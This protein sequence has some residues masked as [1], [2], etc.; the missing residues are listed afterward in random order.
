MVERDRTSE[1]PPAK[2]RRRPTVVC[3]NCK[4]RKSKCDRLKPVCGN[5]LRLGDEATCVYGLE[6]AGE[7]RKPGT[8]RLVAQCFEMVRSTQPTL[9]DLQPGGVLIQCKRSCTSY[10]APLTPSAAK[11]RDP[12]L[13]ALGS[14]CQLKCT[15]RAAMPA[16][17]NEGPEEA[18]LRGSLPNSMRYIESIEQNSSGQP[19]SPTSKHK[20]MC[21]QLFTKFGKYRRDHTSSTEDDLEALP[22][23]VPAEKVFF[24]YIWPHF[25][26]H[27]LSLCPIFDEVR[28]EKSLRL[29]YE[30]F[31]GDT[32]PKPDIEDYACFSIVLL[33]TCLVQLSLK[34]AQSYTQG[35]VN[36]GVSVIMK[37]D[38][39]KFISMVNNCISRKKGHR[40]CSLLRL[41]CLLLLRFYHWCAPDDGDGD[42]LQYSNMMMGTIVAACYSMGIDWQCVRDPEDFTNN[43]NLC[44]G[45]MP[46]EA[47]YDASD[48]KKIWATVLHWDRKLSLLTGQRCLVGN[49][50]KL[51]ALDHESPPCALLKFDSLMLKICN[52]VSDDPRRVDVSAVIR[53]IE[54]LRQSLKK[55]TGD[56]AVNPVLGFEWG[57]VIA[58]LELTITH[59]HMVQ[60]ERTE[61]PDEFYDC[62]Q[63]LF[64]KVL[65]ITKICE[66]YLYSQEG[67]DPSA[68]FY[69]N[70]II[71]IAFSSVSAIFPCLI[72]RSGRSIEPHTKRTLLIFYRNIL[73]ASFNT[74]GVEYYTC[75]RRMFPSKLA[76][77]TLSSAGDGDPWTR[78]LEFI[79]SSDYN[80]EYALL[81]RS[82]VF[83]QFFKSY[84]K[85]GNIDTV[86][87]LWSAC[88]T[89]NDLY[90]FDLDVK[91]FG[92]QMPF[93]HSNRY[94]DYDVFAAFFNNAK[95][96][97]LAKLPNSP[98][99]NGTSPGQGTFSD[100]DYG[101][102][103]GIEDYDSADFLDF[104]EPGGGGVLTGLEPQGNPLSY[105]IS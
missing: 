101:L 38:T 105:N 100:F 98:A 49:S 60:S 15:K 54:M 81:Q 79:V 44:L 47:E 94:N 55:D 65:Q 18:S 97:F 58:L 76:Y 36:S 69:T 23:R 57:I 75:F 41:Q 9:I 10:I 73:S 6:P 53:L 83:K 2:K 48:Y 50:L 20:N 46:S 52:M 82:N 37:I 56:N 4:R 87:S 77:K 70:K 61:S 8:S 7:S 3:T 99:H 85:A 13:Q 78:I 89:P 29:V 27:V 72:L 21:R 59:A 62:I 102:L 93:S 14:I 28:L 74:I 92:L 22:S 67:L 1:G 63:G 96:P 30:R 34:F 104:F 40:K 16:P 5:C 88:Y 25:V 66:Q 35:N 68:R 24:R 32:H 64:E 84:E 11:Q 90:S 19:A 12:Y 91:S 86:A 31:S 42:H 80:K 33:I 45:L 39:S 103:Q 71:D 95:T 26:T 51:P 43:F 17:K